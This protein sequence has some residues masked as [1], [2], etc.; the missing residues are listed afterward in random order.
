VLCNFNHTA[1]EDIDAAFQNDMGNVM[2]PPSEAELFFES[3]K[4]QMRQAIGC[5]LRERRSSDVN[6]E[7]KNLFGKARP[8]F[9][10]GPYD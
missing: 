4:Q 9:A 1:V 8:E 2:P 6:K 3:V 7:R 10:P 5:C